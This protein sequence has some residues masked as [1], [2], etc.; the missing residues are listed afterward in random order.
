MGMASSVKRLASPCLAFL[1]Q[2]HRQTNLPSIALRGPLRS[3]APLL[4]PGYRQPWRLWD[5]NA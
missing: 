5:Q 3:K 1:G 2:V 4:G